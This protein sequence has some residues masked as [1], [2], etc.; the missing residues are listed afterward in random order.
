[1][2]SFQIGHL[3]KSVGVL[4]LKQSSIL[5]EETLCINT[6]RIEIMKESEI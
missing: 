3:M 5:Q 6:N 4:I 2:N 1:M